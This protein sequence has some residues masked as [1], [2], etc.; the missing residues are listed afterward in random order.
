M[1]KSDEDWMK[2]CMEHRVE[3]RRLVGRAR[4][5]CLESVKRVWN[6]LRSTEKMSMTGR[7]GET[8]L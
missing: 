5:T 7:K 8:M 6:N 3:G 4:R 1:R 2:K